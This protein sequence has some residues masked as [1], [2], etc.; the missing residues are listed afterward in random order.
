[1]YRRAAIGA[2]H[3]TERWLTEGMGMLASVFEQAPVV[4]FWLPPASTQVWT[5]INW[6]KFAEQDVEN[7]ETAK[8]QPNMTKSTLGPMS[9]YELVDTHKGWKKLTQ[10]A[11]LFLKGIPHSE[12]TAAVLIE[13]VG[14]DTTGFPDRLHQSKLLRDGIR[15]YH[16]CG[17]NRHVHM[18]IS[19]L[20]RVV[21]VRILR[22]DADGIPVVEKTAVLTGGTMV[23]DILN[24]FAA[25]SP[26]LLSV[27]SRWWEFQT[28]GT[29]GRPRYTKFH[30]TRVLGGGLH[31]TVFE[32]HDG[33]VKEQKHDGDCEAEAQAL[34]KLNEHEVPY[35]PT[36]LGL[37]KTNT[38]F[39]ASP[40][41]SPARQLQGL[42]RAWS[43]GAHLVICLQEA[44]TKAHLCHRDI[45]PDNVVI[46]VEQQVLT[47]VRSCFFRA[48][49]DM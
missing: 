25:A 17:G 13:W 42:A 11:T 4:N 30:A 16:R 14:Q 21:A 2:K 15:M 34:K 5:G 1:M 9:P 22:V 8:I 43:L 12:L 31:G 3:T 18:V 33:F 40:V 35:V 44:H 6:S 41:G 26:S 7:T 19:D 48:A 32:L 49:P 45:R 47:C 10:D 23:Q 24:A 36:L 38:A 29:E 28:G 37:D 20:C 27:A 46:S 39:R